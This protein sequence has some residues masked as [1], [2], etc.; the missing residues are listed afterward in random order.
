MRAGHVACVILLLAQ[1]GS[2]HSIA[3][4]SRDAMQASSFQALLEKLE[5][6]PTDRRGSLT[7]PNRVQGFRLAFGESGLAVKSRE[8]GEP[9]V[10]LGLTAFGRAGTQRPLGDATARAAGGS[11]VERG[12][13]SITE[14][15]LNLPEGVEHG[16]TLSERAAGHGPLVL[17]VAVSGAET[18]MTNSEAHFVSRSGQALRYGSLKA[19]DA[20]G[21][22][23]P[24]R[25]FASPGGLRIEVDD[26]SA[27]YPIVI[28]PL[29]TSQVWRANGNLAGV[30]FG[31]SVASAGDVN[32]DGYA[33]VVV[34]AQSFDNGEADEGGA[35]LFL[36]SP[37]GLSQTPAWT[38]ESNQASAG[39]GISVASAGDTNGDGFSDVVVGASS[40]DNG[41]SDEGRV[42]V[43]LGSS[44]GLS[45]TA[46]WTAESDQVGAAFGSTVAGAGDVNG[47]GYTEV[48]VGASS[49]DN[50]E[51]NEGRA[52]LYLGS[53]EGLIQAPAWTA[54]G[55]QA[56]SQFGSSVSSAGDVDRDGYSDVMVGAYNFDNGEV[57][58]GRVS[59][60][61][62]SSSGLKTA[63]AW[64]TEGNRVGVRY[65][66]SVASAGDVNC[67]GYSDVMV[68]APL[69]TNV[70]TW[71]GRAFVFL[72]SASGPSQTPEW[73]TEVNL[74]DV[75]YASSVASAGDVNGDGCSDVLVGAY[76]FDNGEAD[77]GRAFLYLGS[78]SGLEPTPEW[79]A[80]GNQSGASFGSSL[81]GAGDVNG[82]GYSDV[83]V[84]APLMDNDGND[85]G[86]AYLYP[87]SVR[88]L[89]PTAAWTAD[90]N[91]A[92]ALF[93]ATVASAGDVNGDGYSDVVVGAPNYDS[94]DSDLGQAGRAFLYLGSA[95]GLATMPAWSAA[96]TIQD[97]ARFGSGV[98][99][100]G[101]VNGDGF[102]DV[103]V[104]AALLDNREVDEGRV[105]LYLGSSSGL[106][107]MAAWTAE[108]DQ[109]G[110]NFGVALASAGDVNGD[111][112][113]DVVVGAP[114]FGS[115][116]AGEG[117]AFLYLGS[118][119]GL[120]PTASWTAES[121]Q[122]GSRFGSSVASA[123]DVNGDGFSDVVVG[124]PTFDNGNTDNG[125]AFLYL[126]S[127]IGLNPAPAW[128]A[129]GPHRNAQFG[130]SVASG[131]DVNG[132]GYSDAVVGAFQEN[133]ITG[134]NG[135]P[136]GGRVYLYLGSLI[137]LGTSESWT[138]SSDQPVASL[139][140]SVASAGDVNGD[141]YSDVV[142][143]APNFDN[144]GNDSGR[145]SLYF[146]S[147]TGL[148]SMP[149]WTAF[150]N[151]ANAQFGLSVAT[152]GDVNG[153]GYS[154]V[155]VGAPYF[156][157]VQ[158]DWGRAFLFLGGDPIPRLSREFSQHMSTPGAAPVRL[159]MLG[160]NGLVTQGRIALET[161]V[162][163]LGVRFDGLGVVRSP[164]GLGGQRLVA[165]WP[166]LP[167][168]RYHWRARLVTGQERGRWLSYGGNSEA[169]AD[170]ILVTSPIA[171]PD[172][173]F[174][175]PDA[176]T[177]TASDGGE[178]ENQSGTPR[179][180]SVGCKCATTA[181][182]PALLLSL[183]WRVSRRRR[184]R[185]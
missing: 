69:F 118:A 170:F 17:S 63:P 55:N 95:A 10:S 46:A 166:N 80:E 124:A 153:D 137:G 12:W 148:S 105:F 79:T 96:D 182:S 42:F 34:G 71:E 18:V 52:F 32:G 5:Y 115:G 119:N 28:D 134:Y 83:L 161:E 35:F 92:A 117:R 20:S 157:N 98:A 181:G 172:A 173:G 139:G 113:S 144:A 59:L 68:G 175:G 43:Y 66:S 133:T 23:L 54:E 168:G 132:D 86:Y 19:L 130:C 135:T 29:L 127:E 146:G 151:Q 75:R 174:G 141:G 64:T 81:A 103:L 8:S 51:A 1:D 56:N 85:R 76:G 53:A 33:D 131:G 15:F 70:E 165:T 152:A 142:V 116:E 112:F 4:Q 106:N 11:K 180:Y 177:D 90:S 3:H 50:G 25:M 128:T 24:S 108:S 94:G 164:L 136:A 140:L 120:S 159:S 121:N 16:W 126:G 74:A 149:A 110:A 129:R 178:I 104:A 123:G 111:G 77:E 13:D 82:D 37:T 62:G 87:G 47:D 179:E 6:Q 99:S 122:A 125:Q 100:A 154:D 101:D 185:G 21:A 45:P 44:N 48:L 160:F 167:I 169:E 57:D 143:G 7:A 84:G 72:G 65:G 14:W 31:S 36:G 107:T 41:Q 138:A 109:A 2:W 67:D 114:G 93:G 60:Y 73:T 58:E 150:G 97:Q 147:A 171:E 78:A 30:L 184:R 145:A 26:D 40:F 9:L 91:Q 183:V 88:G 49:F 61:L 162:K 163:P 22:E 27:R 156:D 38:A 158:N 155:V 39:L 102:S 176:G 89:G